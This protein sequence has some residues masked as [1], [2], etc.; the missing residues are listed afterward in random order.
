MRRPLEDRCRLV[1]LSKKGCVHI[2]LHMLEPCQSSISWERRRISRLREDKR[3]QALVLGR[4]GSGPAGVPGG[5]GSTLG[6]GLAG[7]PAWGLQGLHW[8][9]RCGGTR[10]GHRDAPVERALVSLDPRC[11]DPTPG[12]GNRAQ[13][14]AA[15]L[16]P[17]WLG[18]RG[19]GAPVEAVRAGP[20]G[21]S[22]G[23]MNCSPC[24][25]WVRMSQ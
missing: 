17:V 18:Q 23:G 14:G 16:S 3:I 8:H 19:G 6:G 24:P 11:Q 9:P 7:D 20:G 21:R 1:S 12:R 22:L 15:D 13:G 2:L 25:E 4:Q 10:T 5:A